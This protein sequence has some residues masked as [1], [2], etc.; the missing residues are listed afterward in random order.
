MTTPK[1][2]PRRPRKAAPPRETSAEH[3]PEGDEH[4]VDGADERHGSAGSGTASPRNVRRA[5][6]ETLILAGVPIVEAARRVGVGERTARRYAAAI[7]DRIEGVVRDR[8][9]R[10]TELLDRLASG[11]D[12]A[13]E[14]LLVASCTSWQA[15]ARMLALIAPRRHE[16]SGPGGG[17]LQLDH[18]SGGARA[19]FD[20]LRA[21]REEETARTAELERKAA[22]DAA[23]ADRFAARL[24]EAGIDPA[25]VDDDAA[26][27]RKDPPA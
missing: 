11:G 22:R 13:V 20:R 23:R 8:E 3:A 15:A 19:A 14:T 10:A 1:R 12:A 21:R 18:S 6:V 9:Q 24:R 26:D 16:L 2:R 27:T 5:E 17:P 25:D 4:D 7:R